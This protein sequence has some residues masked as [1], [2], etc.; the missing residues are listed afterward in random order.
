MAI[1]RLTHFRLSIPLSG[2]PPEQQSQPHEAVPRREWINTYEHVFAWGDGPGL[3][4]LA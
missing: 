2:A 1:A 3:V 4:H